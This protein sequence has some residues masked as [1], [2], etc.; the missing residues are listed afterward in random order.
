V[1]R[2]FNQE[3]PN[4]VIKIRIYNFRDLREEEKMRRKRD[5]DLRETEC[6]RFFLINFFFFTYKMM[7]VV[8]LLFVFCLC[9]KER[10]R[11]NGRL[12]YYLVLIVQRNYK[13]VLYV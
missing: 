12:H 1:T 5:L 6:G 11:K 4:K 9:E 13:V 8:A 10:K 2:G 7:L 3:N